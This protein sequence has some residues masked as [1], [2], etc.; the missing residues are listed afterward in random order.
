MVILCMSLGSF[1]SFS[2]RRLGDSANRLID[3]IVA[4]R[5]D[6]ARETFVSTGVGNMS[7]TVMTESAVFKTG[8]DAGGLRDIRREA[9]VLEYLDG[10]LPDDVRV[11]RLTWQSND[12]SIYAMERVAGGPLT[13]NLLLQL[14]EAER[15][16]LA[17]KLGRFNATLATAILPEERKAMGLQTVLEA[18]RLYPARL[19]EKMESMQL[20]SLL[21][22]RAS[23]ANRL[24][25]WVDKNFDEAETERRLLFVHPD[26]H[27]DNLFYCQQTKQLS[28]IDLGSGNLQRAEMLFCVMDTFF[29][30][31]FV[32]RT[33]QAFNKASGLNITREDVDVHLALT[34]LARPP[35]DL[36]DWQDF[37][38]RLDKAA[39]ALDMIE[40]GASSPPASS[41]WQRQRFVPNMR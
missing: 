4:E 25:E 15:L 37:M 27:N 29:P 2:C 16:A 30:E 5:P 34:L 8:K 17:D 39:T 19:R 13:E 35:H 26:L 24:L 3:R 40:G 28:V 41:Q 6:L 32:D 31:P 10:H 7:V 18:D 33:H 11:P 22:Q 12:K 36:Q 14:P 20:E 23:I 38:H 1:N 21:G 9:V